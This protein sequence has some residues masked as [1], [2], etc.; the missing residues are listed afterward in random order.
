LR[1]SS[2]FRSHTRT[3][4]RAL[5]ATSVAAVAGLSGVVAT[6][7]P[8]AAAPS[9]PFGS[10][11]VWAN[12]PTAA[13]YVPSA[14]YQWNSTSPTVAVNRI[15]RTG[16][17]A[18]TVYLPGLGVASG[19]VLVTAYGSSKDYCKVAS[20][21]PSGTR[22]AINVRC[23]NR[24]GTKVNTTFTLS[25]SNRSLG[26]RA[27]VWANRPTTA[28][29]TPSAPYQANSTGATNR[30]TRS[31]KGNYRVIL[32]NLGA[33]AGHVQ[34]TAYGSGTQR[35]KTSDWGP[36]GTNQ[37]IGVRCFT[38]A[39]AAA[40]TTFTLT[41]VRNGNV[42]GQ[43]V[44]NGTTGNPTAYAWANLPTTRSYTP[45]NAYRFGAAKATITRVGT[46]DYKFKTPLNL[47]NGNVQ[48]TAYGSGSQHCKVAYWNNVDGIRV[49]C[50]TAKG[51]PVNT[52]FDVAFTGR[53]TI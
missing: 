44:G 41:Y 43:P 35:C 24:L 20:W 53:S 27:Y 45:S 37:S 3:H 49:K 16:V 38:V 2:A 32:P 46:G 14:T 47:A 12:N 17:G 48:V 52:Q 15:T 11:F 36:S 13:S 18:Y 4:V 40:D 22:Q 51:N 19:T 5:I 39:G 21:G 50:F 31:G 7:G 8:A 23:Y 29:Y 9:A 33:G 30:I 6:A 34:V 42:L 1:F 10:A 26:N 28:S 25:Y